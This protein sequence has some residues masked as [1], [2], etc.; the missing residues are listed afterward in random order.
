MSES[1]SPMSI[2][3]MVDALSDISKSF[4]SNQSEQSCTL[5]NVAS[6]QHLVMTRGPKYTAKFLK[7]YVG[8]EDLLKLASTSE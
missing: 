3:D 2:M 7:E 5:A 4:F 6:F 1:A 8:S